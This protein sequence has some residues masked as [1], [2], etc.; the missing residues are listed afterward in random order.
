[1][2]KTDSTTLTRRDVL[3]T[4]AAAGAMSL[5]GVRPARADV[6]WTRFAGTTLEANLI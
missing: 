4:G 1:M 2:I 3:A 6:D 5:A